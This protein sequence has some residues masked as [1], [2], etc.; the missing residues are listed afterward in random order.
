MA[1]VSKKKLPR[2][3]SKKSSS[4][5]SS[6]PPKLKNS[7]VLDKI[8]TTIRS[9]VQ[10]DGGSYNGISRIAISKY[11]KF[12]LDYDNATA[13]KRTLRK[14]VAD[15][16]LEQKGQSFHIAGDP[17]PV[18]RSSAA[19]VESTDLV[20]GEGEIAQQGDSL[21][22][23]YVG[24]LED[25]A[26]F[27]RS[28]V[29]SFVLGAG[30]VI[31]GWDFGVEGMRVGGRRKLVIPARLGYGKRGSPPDIPPNA[32]LTFEIGLKEVKK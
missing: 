19:S 1:P 27:D 23:S 20:L 30:E 13:V 5:F 9:L 4:S 22:L 12:E 8:K 7:T 32:T 17:I 6:D 28:K 24:R 26:V 18:G 15:G 3:S 25:G 29:F 21:R 10:L 2:S 11:L 31:K 16:I 14:A